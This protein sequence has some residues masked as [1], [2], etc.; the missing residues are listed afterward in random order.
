MKLLS[1]QEK[2]VKVTAYVVLCFMSIL[3][4]IPFWLL[5]SSSISDSNY[6]L[7]EGYRFLP[8]QLSLE[9]YRYIGAQ[10]GQIGHAYIITITV[11]V[12]GTF[13]SLLIATMLAYGLTQPNLPGGKII[14]GLIMFTMLFSGGIVPQYMIYSNYLGFKNSLLGLIVPNLLT[15][16][17]SVILVRNY[18]VTA[19]PG[20][21]RE[22]MEIDGAGPFRVYFRMMLPLSTP[23]LATLGIMAAITYW[24]DWSNALYYITDTRFFSVQQLLNEMNNNIL[25]MANNSGQLQGVDVSTLPTI[26][27]RMAIAVI[28]ILPIIIVY[29]FFQKYFARGI[30]VGAVKG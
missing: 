1:R 14:M 30:T 7:A 29:P 24:N 2:A 20:E 10:W 13:F 22:A 19:I 25:F 8:K 28:G 4:I 17:F 26:T 6:V 16:A 27:M 18:F 12:L 21:L 9:A 23:I 5:V 11:T 3:S 15:N